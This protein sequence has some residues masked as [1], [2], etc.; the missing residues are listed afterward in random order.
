MADSTRH[1]LICSCDDTMPLDADAVRRGCRGKPTTATQLCRAELD[2]FRAIAAEDTPLTVACNQEASL[3]SEMA[4][5]SGRASPVE[6]VNIR[7]AAGWSSNA[8]K[9]G[10]KMA[11]LLAAAAEPTPPVP[12]VELESGGGILICGRD[13]TAV[14]AANLLKD[15]LDVTVL[16]EPPA[17]IVPP[18]IADFPIAK[19]KL[20]NASGH[21]GAFE[22]TV[23]DFALAMPSS[24]SALAF[25]PSRNNA[26][27]SCDII[28]DL[29]G[30]SS[31]FPAA[32]LRDGYLRADPKNPA[33]MLRAA[34]KARGL[35]VTFEKPRYVAYHAALCAHSRS[36][37]VGCTRCLEL[38][39][40]SAITPAGDHVA[41]DAN[42]CGGCGLRAAAGR[43]ADAQ[44][45]RDADRLPRGGRRTGG[46]AGA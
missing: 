5:E 2:R 26:R 42:V 16:I 38:C 27:S 19:G 33:A 15:H 12:S 25:G 37:I 11:A 3:F 28:L 32:D 20:R 46:A 40:T 21:L 43:C 39:P 31:L 41:I 8:A 9:A 29:T 18:R 44:A 10:P 1:I 4:V 30:G 24:R 14:E 45:A 13:E 34:L 22:V 36:Q 35:A 17:A 23:D 6:F 7:E